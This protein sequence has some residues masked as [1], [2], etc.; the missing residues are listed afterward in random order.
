MLIVSN[1][2]PLMAESAMTTVLARP[3]GGYGLTPLVFEPT[4]LMMQG[5][6][7][8]PTK[9]R[10]N[11]GYELIMPQF[12]DES[13]DAVDNGGK[14]LKKL[15]YESIIS[16]AAAPSST[17]ATKSKLALA[18]A[19][20]ESYYN[21][22]LSLMKMKHASSTSYNSIA[23]MSN[24]LGGYNNNDDNM[25]TYSD[26]SSFSGS[27]GATFTGPIQSLRSLEVNNVQD[28]YDNSEPQVIDIPPSA[29]PIVINFRTS[30]SQ[31]QIH[32]SHEASEPKE[33]QETS[34]QD[35]PH[36][37]KHSVTKPVIQ[38]VHEI[39]MPYRRIIQEIRPVEEEIKTIVSRSSGKVNDAGDNYGAGVG[40]A[41]NAGLLSL[42]GPSVGNSMAAASGKKSLGSNSLQYSKSK[43]GGKQYKS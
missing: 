13:T 24:S 11:S 3:L 19:N 21:S 26:S 30:A 8:T 20:A 10:K 43:S 16:A 2:E 7:T 5:S 27:N 32:Q 15:D 18:N 36:F 34:S 41:G 40:M 9:V 31:I 22:M 12:D 29:M 14:S 42:G 33:V 23:P 1:E 17:K 37:L 6:S 39:I 4:P 28:S 38:E 35:E 25:R